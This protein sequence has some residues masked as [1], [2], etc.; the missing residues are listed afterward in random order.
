[1][2]MLIAVVEIINYFQ[3]N[4]KGATLNS[5]KISEMSLTILSY[6][7]VL[8]RRAH[9]VTKKHISEVCPSSYS[10]HVR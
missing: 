6:M 9:L 5:L 10:L 2:I 4:H 8:F 7:H 1:M 3:R